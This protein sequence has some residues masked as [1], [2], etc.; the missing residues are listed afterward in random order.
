M[1]HVNHVH[2]KKKKEKLFPIAVQ[3]YKTTEPNIA[4]SQFFFSHL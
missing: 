1:I 2:K 3:K 4:Y